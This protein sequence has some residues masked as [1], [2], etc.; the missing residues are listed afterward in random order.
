MSNKI[1]YIYGYGS[2]PRKSSTMKSLKGVIAEMGFNLVSVGYSHFS[3]FESVNFLE[4]HIKTN[5]IKYIIGHSLGGFYALCINAD[6]KKIVINPC[7]KPHIELPKLD[8]F[9]QR[10]DLESYEKCYEKF[11]NKDFCSS[12][13]TLGLFGTHDELLCYYYDFKELSPRAYFF[14][15]THRPTKESFESV[16]LTIAEFLGANINR[17]FSLYE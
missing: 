7:L 17:R 15:A 8:D 14:P 11:I 9:D 2:N 3:P 6:V 5:E 12:F 13:E 1:L 10:V 16:K 4:D